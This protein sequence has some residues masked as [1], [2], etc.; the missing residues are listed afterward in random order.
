MTGPE[1]RSDPPAGHLGDGPDLAD[2]HHLGVALR[3]L[4][5]WLVVVDFD[6]TLAR[7]VDHP[8]LASPAPGALATLQAVTARTAVAVLSGRPIAD[9]RRRLDGLV[10]AY[11]G[12]HGAELVLAD[13]SDD[14]LVDPA[15]VTG[16]LDRAER[17]I[18][19]LVDEEP[20]W[21]VERKQASL[22]VHHRLADADSV[23]TY[24]AR[25]EAL[26]EHHASEPP[27]FEVLA[28]KAVLE[29]R[30][31]SANKGRALERIAERTPELVPLVIGDDITDED[32]FEVARSLG[33]RAILVAET[34]RPTAATDRVTD[35]DAVVRLL[36]ALVG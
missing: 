4:D 21:L 15:T 3:P 20:G 36:A 12:G 19:D 2:P 8:D 23:V 5:R 13:G 1:P 16:T 34:A 28:G 29:L 27:G 35:P 14:P 33:G 7:I 22:A 30:P 9:V 10:A 17:V 6:G 24:G 32:A 11:A 31:S 25:V 26:L 18:R